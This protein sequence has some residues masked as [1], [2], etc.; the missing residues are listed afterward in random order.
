MGGVWLWAWAGSLF[1]SLLEGSGGEPGTGHVL[2]K[3]EL[4]LSHCLA[5]RSVPVAGVRASVCLTSWAGQGVLL[6]CP[7]GFPKQSL[8]LRTGVVVLLVERTVLV[9]GPSSKTPAWHPVG[10]SDGVGY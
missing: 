3:S 1:D 8:A 10:P 9:S 4:M 6:A 7:L 2:R 5:S